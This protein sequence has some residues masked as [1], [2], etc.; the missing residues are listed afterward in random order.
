MKKIL[1]CSLLVWGVSHSQLNAQW[2]ESGK[3]KNTIWEYSFS[4]GKGTE[5]GRGLE[6]IS[7]PSVQDFLPKPSSGEVRISTA[8]ISLTDGSSFTLNG[9]C[10]T[11]C[12]K[13]VHTSGNYPQPA[14]T[15]FV[16]RNFA[17]TSKVMSAHFK[18]SLNHETNN[19]Q[20]IWYIAVGDASNELFTNKNIAPS[21]SNNG[22]SDHTL[23]TVLR[24]RKVAFNGKYGLQVRHGNGTIKWAWQ[25]VP[26]VGLN[27]GKEYQI[28]L[29]F[30]NTDQPQDY[31]HNGTAKTLAAAAYHI[32]IDNVQKGEN[33]TTLNRN[34]VHRGNNVN[35]YTGN[36]SGFAFMSREG[37]QS[38][39]DGTAP[40]D[41]VE[42]DNSASVNLSDFKIIHKKEK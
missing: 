24:F 20:A 14:P 23:Y 11:P 15:K 41:P 2:I 34:V 12:L 42:Q 17:G 8:D 7:I 39:T 38:F 32:Y 13:M 16:A 25:N 35:Q 33:L 27:K 40:A 29:F 3:S 26:G 5:K 28:D 6:K 4:G 22:P 9:N 18:M 21:I 31:T 19:K 1:I 10:E 36:L 37:A 30:N